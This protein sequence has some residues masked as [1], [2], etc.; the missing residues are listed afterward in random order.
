MDGLTR[1]IVSFYPTRFFRSK[2]SAK[3]QDTVSQGG[4]ELVTIDAY[5]VAGNDVLKTWDRQ[6]SAV[7]LLPGTCEGEGWTSKAVRVLA[8]EVAFSNQAVVMVADVF[9]RCDQSS[10]LTR[11]DDLLSCIRYLRKEL[12]VKTVSLLGLGEGGGVAMEAACSL[13]DVCMAH[14]YRL[15]GSRTDRGSDGDVS[16]EVRISGVVGADPSRFFFLSSG[17]PPRSLDLSSPPSPSLMDDMDLQG[18]LLDQDDEGEGGEDKL[19]MEQVAQ[20][21]NTSSLSEVEVEQHLLTTSKEREKEV[22]VEQHLLTTSFEEEFQ[23]KESGDDVSNINSDDMQ[24][25]NPSMSYLEDIN[26]RINVSL[27][28]SSVPVEDISSLLPR[29]VVAVDPIG[30]DASLVGDT[31]R[32]PTLIC[33]GDHDYNNNSS[34]SNDNSNSNS[35]G[36]GWDPVDLFDRLDGRRWQ[37]LDFSVRMYEGR[38]RHFLLNPQTDLDHKCS[39]VSLPPSYLYSF[40]IN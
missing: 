2:Q 25:S 15:L 4:G 1:K 38:G 11:L 17:P 27:E 16:E 40:N 8:D 39:Q 3:L 20:V 21:I 19:S 37:I 32:I 22:E 18:A 13:Q 10:S 31:L 28:D 5:V 29:C 24:Y 23:V 7:L 33:L 9:R 30:F 14:L 26:E 34:N 6:S 35:I 36:R 12:G